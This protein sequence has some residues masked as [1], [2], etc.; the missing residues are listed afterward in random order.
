MRLL[1]CSL[2]INRFD[3]Q[4]QYV[5]DNS[6]IKLSSNRHEYIYCSM[7]LSTFVLLEINATVTVTADEY[8]CSLLFKTKSIKFSISN[9]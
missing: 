4:N 1:T 3:I 9:C 7:Y 8:H 2:L 5:K 6:S